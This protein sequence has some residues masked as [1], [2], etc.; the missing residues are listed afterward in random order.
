MHRFELMTW[1]KDDE[2]SQSLGMVYE[3]ETIQQAEARAM[4]DLR[5]RYGNTVHQR[6]TSHGG[7]VFAEYATPG[8]RRRFAMLWRGPAQ[9]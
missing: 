2:R 5:H 6:N 7:T 8:T 9:Q 4:Y 1:T 3:A